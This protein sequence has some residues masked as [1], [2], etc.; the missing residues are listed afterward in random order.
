M[1]NAISP[2]GAQEIVRKHNVKAKPEA[3]WSLETDDVNADGI[4]DIIIKNSA[5][6]M[7]LY[8]SLM[9]SVPV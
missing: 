4:P 8:I 1:K 2:Q 9:F 5:F 6:L 3:H 7:N